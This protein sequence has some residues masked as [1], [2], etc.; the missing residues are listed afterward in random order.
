[1]WQWEEDGRPDMGHMTIP[2]VPE[3]GDIFVKLPLPVKG[4]YAEG[5]RNVRTLTKHDQSVLKGGF[6]EEMDTIVHKS[7]IWSWRWS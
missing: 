3:E 5:T 2:P 1:M 4:K 7:P 6:R